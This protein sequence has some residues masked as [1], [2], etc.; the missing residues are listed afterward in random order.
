MPFTTTS[1]TH[2]KDSDKNFLFLSVDGA[3]ILPMSFS[4]CQFLKENG[5]T[6]LLIDGNLGV[7]TQDEIDTDLDKVLSDKAAISKAIHTTK[8]VSYLSGKASHPFATKSKNYQNQFLADLNTLSGNFDKIFAALSSESSN[9]QELWLSWA[10]KKYLFFQTE[11]LFLEKT[12]EFLHNYPNQID[13]LISLNK[14]PHLSRLAW[15]RLK[16]I[17]PDLPELIIDIKQTVQE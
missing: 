13:G 4:V 8:G 5:Y 7:S 16:K 12:A 2:I 14:N 1:T 17:I 10:E 15:I 11:N 9:L 6:T 3:N